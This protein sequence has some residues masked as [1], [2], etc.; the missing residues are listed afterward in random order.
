M[1]DVQ[2]LQRGVILSL[3]IAVASLMTAVAPLVLG[4][5]SSVS[6]RVTFTDSTGTVAAR[7]GIDRGE[8]VIVDAKGAKLFGF[9]L[10]GE[11]PSIRVYDQQYRARLRLEIGD[12][13][14]QLLLASDSGKPQIRLAAL[15]AASDVFL[16]DEKGY[17]RLGLSTNPSGAGIFLADEAR[18]PR[19]QINTDKATSRILLFDTLN[20]QIFSATK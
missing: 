2:K 5:D 15:R 20:R 14:P 9:G 16:Y 12:R 18:R 7:M 1:T 3:F 8:L 11:M 19:V 10:D 13:G 4:N 6:E 17:R